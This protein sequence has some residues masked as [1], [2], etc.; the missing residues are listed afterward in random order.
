MHPGTLSGRTTFPLSNPIHSLWWYFY[1]WQSVVIADQLVLQVGCEGPERVVTELVFVLRQW[2]ISSSYY[3]W[4]QEK[5]TN[6]LGIT[7]YRVPVKTETG[8]WTSYWLTG[9]NTFEDLKKK[10]VHAKTD[11]WN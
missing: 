11:P 7:Y 1:H 6:E 8:F 10:H 2:Q 4:G 5:F 9:T 3:M